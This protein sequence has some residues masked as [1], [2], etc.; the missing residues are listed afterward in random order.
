MN[1]STARTDRRI[2]GGLSRT[3]PPLP[4]LRRPA[5]PA[6]PA[7]ALLAEKTTTT[8]DHSYSSTTT[9]S[10]TERA[11]T[12]RPRGAVDWGRLAPSRAA[13]R[14]RPDSSRRWPG[15]GR[16]FDSRS[17]LMS[18]FGDRVWFWY[19][20]CCLWSSRRR[21]LRPPVSS[22]SSR[23]RQSLPRPQATRYPASSPRAP[24]AGKAPT[25]TGPDA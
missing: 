10:I 14:G 2:L 13:V 20:W 18:S 16:A 22:S 7:L 12:R 11:T 23:R 6:P 15:G 9:D 3:R 19:E 17:V 8:T 21:V 24:H 5:V 25:P 4:A 1:G